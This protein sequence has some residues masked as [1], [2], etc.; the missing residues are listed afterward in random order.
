MCVLS[1]W[2]ESVAQFSQCLK[3]HAKDRGLESPVGYS[4]GQ[5]CD[6][7]ASEDDCNRLGVKKAAHLGYLGGRYA[8]CE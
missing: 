7:D 5:R 8:R 4:K 1:F 3:Q 6:P 2:A